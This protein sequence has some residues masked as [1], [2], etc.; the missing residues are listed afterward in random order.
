VVLEGVST[1]NYQTR[2]DLRQLIN[3]K[4]RQDIA[5]AHGRTLNPCVSK[6]SECEHC[7]A[8]IP[9]TRRFCDQ[10]CINTS[11]QLDGAA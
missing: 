10:D 9:A 2:H 8:V 3:Q 11:R 7:G 5:Q 4:K 1:V 6:L